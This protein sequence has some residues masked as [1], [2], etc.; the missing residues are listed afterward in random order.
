MMETVSRLKVNRRYESA[1]CAWC[2]D[3]L[4]LGEDGAVCE[5]CEAPHHARCWDEHNGC[6]QAGCVNAPLRQVEAPADFEELSAA[7]DIRCPHCRKPLP[8]HLRKQL[9]AGTLVC[10]GCNIFTTPSGLFEGERETDPEARDAF[11]LGLAGLVVPPILNVVFLASN[12]KSP[13][14]FG[15]LPLVISI[16]CGWSA[17]KKGGAAKDRIAGDQTLKGRGLA[18]AGQFLGG[19]ALIVPVLGTAALILII[20]NG[21]G[22]DIFRP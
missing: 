14:I 9:L 3:A 12:M 21:G 18:T 1:A 2:G 4:R 16:R 5:A 6:G 11:W 22:D 8:P 15:W 7:Y 10:P 17:L 20:M 13:G 19:A